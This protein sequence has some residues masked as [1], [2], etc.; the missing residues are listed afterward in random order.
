MKRKRLIISAFSIL[1]FV[2]P[3]YALAYNMISNGGFEEGF[4]YWNQWSSV[5][6]QLV[7][8]PVVENNYAAYLEGINGI[9]QYHTYGEGD[10]T[11]SAWLQVLEGAAKI[12]ISTRTGQGIDSQKIGPTGEWQYLELT[13]KDFSGIGGPYIYADA[14]LGTPSKFYADSIW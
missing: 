13:R 10:Y 11:V 1:I 9:W 5:S 14:S 3:N 12:G 2:L 4:S 8:D 7:T 6:T